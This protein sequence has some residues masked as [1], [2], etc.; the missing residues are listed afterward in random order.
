MMKKVCNFCNYRIYGAEP[1][2]REMDN[3]IVS[4]LDTGDYT[5]EAV[6]KVVGLT[7]ERVRQIYKRQTGNSYGRKYGLK[8]VELRKEKFKESLK[9]FK[10]NCKGCK[11]PVTKGEA[12]HKSQFCIACHNI[13]AIDNRDPKVTKVCIGC[14]IKFNPLRNWKFAGGGNKFHSLRCYLDFMKKN[15]LST[16]TIRKYFE[17]HK[18]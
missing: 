9:E 10:F 14:G 8:R 7:R 5:L 4:M 17:E 11:K 12:S 16:Y 3:Q 6:G 13:W 18:I 2:H 15:N 1:E